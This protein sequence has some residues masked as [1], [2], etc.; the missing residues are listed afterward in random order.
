MAATRPTIWNDTLSRR[1]ALG[2]AGGL[3]AGLATAR[4]AGAQEA[5]PEP[6][7]STIDDLE[8]FIGEAIEH[9]GVPGAAVAVVQDGEP[10]LVAGYGIREAGGDEPVDADTAFQLASNTKPLTAFTLGTLVDEGLIDW[11][12]PIIEVLP[13]L[14]LQ[15]V[16]A[17]RHVTPRDVLS[18]RSGLPAFTGDLLGYLGYDRAE[19]LHRLRHVPPG[20]SFREVAAYSNLGYFI[21]GEVIARL[22]GAPWEEAMRERLMDPLGMSRSGPSLADLP[23]DGNVAAPHADL[24]GDLVAIPANDHGVHG[25]AGSAF[26]TANDMARWMQMLL[27]GG[28]WDDRQMVEQETL[29]EMFAPSM[30][31]DVAF[32]EV[33]PIDERTGFGYGLGW[34]NFHYRGYEV[35]EKG[36]AL[37]G[38]R[39]V[40]NLVPELGFGIAVLANRNLSYFPE[41]VRAFALEHVLGAWDEDA[42]AEIASRATIIEQIFTTDPYPENP[43]LPSVPLG[44]F[45]GTYQ[46]EL[47]GRFE[48]VMEGEVLGVEAGPAGWPAALPHFNRDTF[49]LDW[50]SPTSVPD[51]T[52]FVIGADGTPVAFENEGLGRFD[53]VESD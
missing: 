12:T 3:A 50:G 28:S 2:M 11:D 48:I 32:T 37:A 4:L 44:A 47:Y 18:H 33:P 51:L 13:E 7:S 35:L 36:G 19:L 16:Y 26:S 15:D 46:N 39:T 14:V 40:V 6:A 22:T 9:Y 5:T 43:E 52:V 25:A 8:T 27:A 31:A 41:A 30:V 23:G 42:Q 20:S 10:A 45:V 53:R 24:D 49:L 17:T 1:K 21:A 34:G 38:V 29:L